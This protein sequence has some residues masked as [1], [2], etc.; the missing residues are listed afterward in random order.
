MPTSKSHPETRRKFFCNTCK[1]ETHHELKAKHSRNTI[2]EYDYIPEA[3]PS[4]WEDVDYKFWVCL[5][6]DTALL[7][8]TT[9]YNSQEEIDYSIHPLR[10]SWKR[11]P[12]EYRT[13]THQLKRVY[14]EIITSYNNESLLAC[15]ILLRALLEGIISEMGITDREAWGLEAKLTKLEEAQHLPA[16]IVQS[17]EGFSLWEM[18]QHIN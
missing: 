8:E 13:L 18:V 10:A 6:C 15:A 17:L 14:K 9:W 1:I 11:Q 5:G 16:N 4:Q 2:I 7:E 3:Q 12:K